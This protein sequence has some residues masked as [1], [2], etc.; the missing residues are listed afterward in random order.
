MLMKPNRVQ[1]FI[2]KKP[3]SE[4]KS[5]IVSLPNEIKKE[6]N[7][8]NE[9]TYNSNEARKCLNTL[10]RLRCELIELKLPIVQKVELMLSLDQTIEALNEL[11]IQQ[12]RMLYIARELQDIQRGLYQIQLLSFTY[13]LPSDLKNPDDYGLFRRKAQEI[14][15][16][17]NDENQQNDKSTYIVYPIMDEY[18]FRCTAAI[19]KSSNSVPMEIQ[20]NF[21]GTVDFAAKASDLDK[22]GP[23]Q[24]SLKIHEAKLM[25][26]VNH[27]IQQMALEYPHQTFKLK[28][29]GHSLGGALAKGFAHSFQRALAVQHHTPDGIINIIKS[30]LRKE[31]ACTKDYQPAIDSLRNKLQD[32]KA[33]FHHLRALKKIEK[34]TVYSLGA[35][36]V[37]IE[38]DRHATLLT[39]YYSPDFLRVYHHFHEEDIIIKFG[40][41]EFLSGK[42]GVP[43]VLINKA[44]QFQI[45]LSPNEIEKHVSLPFPGISNRVM[46]AHNKLIYRSTEE[47]KST[48]LESKNT[49][50]LS[51]KF[52]F[53][54][55][56]QLLYRIAFCF[57]KF[58][59]SF[60]TMV[61]IFPSLRSWPAHPIDK[62]IILSEKTTANAAIKIQ[63][64]YR[65][66]KGL[67]LDSE[68][69]FKQNPL[70]IGFPG[71]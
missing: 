54:P 65:E 33:S 42:N 63:R 4:K 24:I 38:T 29:A 27:L 68:V 31:H 46:A 64:K 28:I 36:G 70:K 22:G 9:G 35:P 30:E 6:I 34:I 14:S 40:E 51:D 5:R 61:G 7:N 26:K 44:I 8:F 69:E 37:S 11:V 10:D 59:A 43:R 45:N 15:A 23:G 39:Y 50:Q 25:E 2:G 32:D 66:L 16:G 60:K 18:G 55:I 12:D 57:A 67:S 1:L 58:A 52:V 56:R 49:Q 48:I 20:I 47:V 53:S 71:L 21:Y 3:I 62:P 41:C 19:P 17:K 13:D